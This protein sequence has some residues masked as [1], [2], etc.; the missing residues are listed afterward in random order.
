MGLI[1]YVVLLRCEYTYCIKFKVI[2]T[3]SYS[4]AFI[5]SRSITPNDRS[6][7][8]AQPIISQIVPVSILH[9]PFVR[10]KNNIFTIIIFPTSISQSTNRSAPLPQNVS[11]T[12]QNTDVPASNLAVDINSFVNDLTLTE[13]RLMNLY[14]CSDDN[15]K[16]STDAVKEFIKHVHTQHRSSQKPSK[17][18]N[19]EQ[20]FFWFFVENEGSILTYLLQEREK[21][22]HPVQ[23][24]YTVRINTTRRKCWLFITKSIKIVYSNALIVRFEL[25]DRCLYCGIR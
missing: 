19:S 20:I 4:N 5:G 12:D 1:I 2:R 17:F 24:V 15:C 25:Q 7:D 16:Y 8:V 23:H 18:Q 10:K 21:L 11:S 6:E 22:T 3:V 13:I 14:K 9:K